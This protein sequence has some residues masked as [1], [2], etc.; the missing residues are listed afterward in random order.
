MSKRGESFCKD[1]PHKS[2]SVKCINIRIRNITCKIIQHSQR[3]ALIVSKRNECG[4]FDEIFATTTIPQRFQLQRVRTKRLI[5]KRTYTTL[6]LFV[7]MH[8]SS[9]FHSHISRK[10][11]QKVSDYNFAHQHENQIKNFASFH[12]HK[13]ITH[14]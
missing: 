14:I 2:S 6:L 3:R 10:N 7:S 11:A 13:R 4:K 9:G 1:P 5:H 12:V 8:F